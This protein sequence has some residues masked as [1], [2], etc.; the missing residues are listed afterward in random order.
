MT[1][2]QA[3]HFKSMCRHMREH[4]EVFMRTL[5]AFESTSNNTLRNVPVARA[6][7]LLDTDYPN[8]IRDCNSVIHDMREEL[9]NE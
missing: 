8:M 2:G 6:D 3:R 5:E 9:Y 7:E 4:V 1:P